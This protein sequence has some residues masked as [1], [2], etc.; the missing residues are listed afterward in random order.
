MLL[1][2]YT[3]ALPS[4]G[5]NF[6]TFWGRRDFIIAVRSHCS[7]I[8]C[9]LTRI[10]QPRPQGLLLV[11]NGGRRNPWPRLLKWLQKFLRNA[12]RKHD[13]RSSFRLNH[14]FRLQKIN[15]AARRW[16][17][18]PKRHFITR[19]VT[20][21]STILGVFQQPWPGVFQTAILNEEKAL[22]TRLRIKYCMYCCTRY[23]RDPAG[24][25]TKILCM[26]KQF[27]ILPYNF[28][29]VLICL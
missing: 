29:T 16:K 7:R 21:Y 12:S 20:K 3:A 14:G 5:S 2:K 18:P 23:H 25:C 9:I 15:R 28:I 22:G 13:E 26:R 17:L 19:D 27:T 11:Q 10:K 6:L 8:R 1:R 4:Q 24:T